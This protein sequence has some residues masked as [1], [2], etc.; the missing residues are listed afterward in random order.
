VTNINRMLM[1]PSLLLPLLGVVIGFLGLLVQWLKAE[2]TSLV[3]L[4]V[5]QIPFFLWI[6]WLALGW[7]AAFIPGGPDQ[8]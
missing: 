2:R 3:I 4:R 8:P 1:N 5:A 6:A 7:I